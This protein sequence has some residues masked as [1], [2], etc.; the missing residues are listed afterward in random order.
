MTDAYPHFQ[1]AVRLEPEWPEA[2]N[3][4]A[5]ILATHPDVTVRQPKRALNLARKA[6]DL[7]SHQDVTILDTLASSF[8]A[9]G[10]FD[11]AVSI[12]E[13]AHKLATKAADKSLAD[14]IQ[15]RLELFV[16]NKPYQEVAEEH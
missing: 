9:N 7:T 5:W 12:A 15:Q 1:E 3:G 2:L 8:A 6:A 14:Q 4:L 13:P 11:R 10:Q 16:Q